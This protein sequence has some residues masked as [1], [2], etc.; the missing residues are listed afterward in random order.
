[1]QEVQVTFGGAR[2][3]PRLHADTSALQAEGAV[4]GEL[5][6]YLNQAGPELRSMLQALRRSMKLTTISTASTAVS[7]EDSLALWAAWRETLFAAIEE[8][9]LLAIEAEEGDVG[10]RRREAVERLE[11][12]QRSLSTHAGSLDGA[13]VELRNAEGKL[14]RTA[15]AAAAAMCPPTP[16]TVGTAGGAAPRC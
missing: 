5:C 9:A 6:L 7:A 2:A 13:N 12:L 14:R 16:P 11:T 10:P 8:A 1:M 15:A 3:P 4:G